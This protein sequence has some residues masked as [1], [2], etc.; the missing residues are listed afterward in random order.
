M[1]LLLG[2]FVLL[3][4]ATPVAAQTGN[5]SAAT[6][7]GIAVLPDASFE[8]MFRK[9]ASPSTDFSRLY[10]W[11]AQMALGVSVLRKGRDALL[12]RSTFQSVGTENVGSQ[13]SVGG[14]GYILSLGYEHTHSPEVT[15]SA[16]LTHLSSHLT[17]DLDEKLEEIR[18]EGGVVPDVVDPSEYNVVFFSARRTLSTWWFTPVVEISIQPV[19]FR[20][21]GQPAGSARPIYLASRSTLWRGIGTSIVATTQ[22]EIGPNAFNYFAVAFQLDGRSRPEGRLQVFVGG[23]PGGGL[24]VS[25]NVGALRDGFALGIRMAFGA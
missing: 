20:F 25:P 23:S 21:N 13:I 24:H 5:Q 22:H 7:E 17:R 3:Q 14:T 16:G 10:S 2:A 8:G 12:F 18:R 15:L 9:F 4:S 11:D 6:A 19:N 1:A